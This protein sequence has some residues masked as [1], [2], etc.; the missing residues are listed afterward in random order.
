MVKV[1]NRLAKANDFKY[2]RK[3]CSACHEFTCSDARARTKAHQNVI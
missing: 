1:V 3:L 2:F